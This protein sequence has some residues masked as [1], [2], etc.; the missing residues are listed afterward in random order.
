M[1]IGFN[2]DVSLKN[3]DWFSKTTLKPTRCFFKECQK[4]F[5]LKNA[6]ARPAC[7]TKKRPSETIFKRAQVPSFCNGNVEGVSYVYIYDHISC[8]NSILDI[9][10]P[11]RIPEFHSPKFQRQ[12]LT[13]KGEENTRNDLLVILNK[14]MAP[15]AS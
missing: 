11:T 2:E 3:D 15:T 8:S 5:Q 10:T 7:G 6:N 12:N 4:C 13:T 1:L 14:S 9:P